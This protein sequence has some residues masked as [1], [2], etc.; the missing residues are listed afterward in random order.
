MSIIR[1]R[2][3]DRICN[4]AVM[5]CVVDVF[6]GIKH[7][8]YA[9]MATNPGLWQKIYTNNSRSAALKNRGFR[10]RKPLK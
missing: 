5:G 7:T 1:E 9:H 6:R 2:V 8:K 3:S 4:L 10:K